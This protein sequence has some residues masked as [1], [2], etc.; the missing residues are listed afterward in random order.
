MLKRDIAD[1]L[2]SVVY[3]RFRKE[4]PERQLTN[5]EMESIWYEIYVKLCRGKTEMEVK[6]WCN[7]V[8]LS[9]EK[10]IYPPIGAFKKCMA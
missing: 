1:K 3:N 2:C 10:E 7:T 4:Q 8:P 9:K 6:E 5:N